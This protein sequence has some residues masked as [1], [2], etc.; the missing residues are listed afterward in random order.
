MGACACAGAG[1]EQVRL[2]Q[3]IARLRYWWAQRADH[4][5]F[6]AWVLHEYDRTAMRRRMDDAEARLREARDALGCK[7][8]T[9]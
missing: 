3:A 1:V 6:K 9:A 4:R 7:G 2:G 5:A 8:E